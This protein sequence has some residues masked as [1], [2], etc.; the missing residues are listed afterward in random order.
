MDFYSTQIEWIKWIQGFRTPV[1]DHLFTYSSWLGEE[2]AYLIAVPVVVHFFDR[3]VGIRL[4]VILLI[5]FYVNSFFKDLLGQPRPFQISDVVRVYPETG[6]GIPSGHAQSAMVFWFFMSSEVKKNGFWWLSVAVVGLISFSRIYL[7]VHFPQDI[8]GGWLLAALLL[9]VEPKLS[10]KVTRWSMAYTNGVLS[11]GAL[12]LGYALLL[13]HQAGTSASAGGA[14]SGLVVGLVWTR[15]QWQASPRF[16]Q[17]FITC[18]GTAIIYF[19]LRSLFL[20]LDSSMELIAKWFRYLCVGLWIGAGST[21]VTKS[22][23]VGSSL[24]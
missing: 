2:W 11:L 22:F 3:R 13:L 7:G 16:V 9:W 18:L 5:S 20:S 19:G 14:L 12:A 4:G 10:E 15:S 23:R 8:L 17:F 6:N 24:Q 1:L 21:W